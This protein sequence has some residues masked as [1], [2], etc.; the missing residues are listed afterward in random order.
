[1]CIPINVYKQLVFDTQLNNTHFMIVFYSI[2][3]HFN[4]P[5]LKI[6]VSHLDQDQ[7]P[8]QI[9]KTISSTSSNLL[10]LQW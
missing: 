6:E 9:Y 10:F 5:Q 2:L 1:M 3:F 8:L 4:L 7:L